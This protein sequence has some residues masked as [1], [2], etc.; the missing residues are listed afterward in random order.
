MRLPVFP[1]P[2][3]QSCA[4]PLWP[5]KMPRSLLPAINKSKRCGLSRDS[6]H[7]RN[8]HYIPHALEY[9]K[10]YSPL[11]KAG[12]SE[13]AEQLRSLDVLGP[14]CYNFPAT[15]WHT[16][17]VK[18]S[19]WEHVRTL[20]AK[21]LHGAAKWRWKASLLFCKLH[22]FLEKG[23]LSKLTVYRCIFSILQFL[24]C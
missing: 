18:M 10:I 23:W 1:V 3:K 16:P 6:W 9:K 14:P 20:F 4:S 7:L 17:G 11:S 2:G 21:T 8:I 13:V 5:V 22:C 24:A 12:K 15:F 19:N